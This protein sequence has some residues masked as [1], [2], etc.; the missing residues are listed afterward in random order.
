MGL[1][2]AWGRGFLKD[3]LSCHF[4]FPSQAFQNPAPN[5]SL[6]S[7]PSFSR[8]TPWATPS[9]VISHS[10]S[11][12]WVRVPPLLDSTWSWLLSSAQGSIGP[13]TQGTGAGTDPSPCLTGPVYSPVKNLFPTGHLL[14][15]PPWLEL[16]CS[17]CPM[18]GAGRDLAGVQNLAF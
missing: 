17:E 18:R 12:L 8:K 10:S 6:H 4:Q 15:E 16:C 7:E 13:G 14:P 1:G 2:L 5:S 9:L 11:G 3:A